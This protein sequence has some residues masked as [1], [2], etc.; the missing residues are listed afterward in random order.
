MKGNE[1]KNERRR[2]KIVGKINMIHSKGEKR[3]RE[4]GRKREGERKLLWRSGGERDGR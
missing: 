4:K 1:Q 2:K 3:R